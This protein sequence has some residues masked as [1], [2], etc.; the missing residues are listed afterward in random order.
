[1]LDFVKYEEL[2]E[3]FQC[4]KINI[5]CDVLDKEKIPY[6]MNSKNRPMVSRQELAR[7]LSQQKPPT[8]YHP[9]S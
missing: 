4:R 9:T 3:I 2:K 7:R 5:L 1:M 8:P 6:I